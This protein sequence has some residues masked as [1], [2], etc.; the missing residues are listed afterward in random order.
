MSDAALVSPKNSVSMAEKDVDLDKYLRLESNTFAQEQEV[1]RILKLMN[2]NNKDPLLVLDMPTD[3]YVTLSVPE[4]VLKKQFRLK[5]LLVHPAFDQL[6]QAQQDIQD[7]EKFRLVKKYIRDARDAIFY[8]QG[9]EKPRDGEGYDFPS[10]LVKYPKLGRL[11][12]LEFIRMVKELEYRDKIRLKNELGR[13]IMA[14]EQL[15]EERKRKKEYEDEWEKPDAERAEIFRTWIRKGRQKVL[16]E[17]SKYP[18]TMS[19]FSINSRLTSKDITN[20]T[21]QVA[22]RIPTEFSLVPNRPLRLFLYTTHTQDAAEGMVRSDSS[23]SRVASEGEQHMALVFGDE[24]RSQT[25][26]AVRDDDDAVKRKMRGCSTLV[27]HGFNAAVSSTAKPVNGYAEAKSQAVYHAATNGGLQSNSSG[28]FHHASDA[29]AANGTE[30]PSRAEPHTNGTAAHANGTDGPTGHRMPTET[31]TVPLVRIHSCCLT[32]ETFGSTR[33]DCA[34]QLQQALKRMSVEGGMV[35]YLAQEGRGIG[36]LDKL[37]AYN[38]IDLGHDTYSAN[39]ALGH[40]P[41]SRNYKVAAMILAD[42]GVH[43]VRVLTNNPEKTKQLERDGI[44]ICERVPMV[45]LSWAA[46]D[47]DSD[48]TITTVVSSLHSDPVPYLS[49]GSAAGSE[50]AANRVIQDRDGYLLT[51]IK[52]MG[53]TLD[54]PPFLSEIGQAGTVDRSGLMLVD[55]EAVTYVATGT[56]VAAGQWAGITSWLVHLSLRA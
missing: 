24:W 20:V 53:H 7:P 52:K 4:K 5:S 8:I 26:E 19:H 47:V 10:L 36:L 44:T 49:H 30:P 34:E 27:D 46:S 43:S 16:Q 2:E 37:F 38:L 51:K 50:P 29:V 48:R 13:E 35:V 45:P 14:D 55:R 42:L 6:Q 54:I 31:A 41:D 22:A 1:E 17:K 9:I 18:E 3:C 28:P 11:I 40:E 23:R 33:C 56:E 12:Q 21:C 15:A 25:L 39:V 32:G